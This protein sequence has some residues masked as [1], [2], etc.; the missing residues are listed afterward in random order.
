MDSNSVDSEVRGS[1]RVEGAGRYAG[2][3]RI[4]HHQRR[5]LGL[6]PLE[7]LHPVRDAR[8]LKLIREHLVLQ[9]CHL[10]IKQHGLRPPHEHVAAWALQDLRFGFG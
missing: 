7:G 8:G 2:H 5:G 1:L 10:E 3:V 6:V 4:K 9:A